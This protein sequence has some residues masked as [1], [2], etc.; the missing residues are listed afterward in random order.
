[1]LALG[2]TMVAHAINPSNQEAEASRSLWIQS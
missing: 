1:M 2:W